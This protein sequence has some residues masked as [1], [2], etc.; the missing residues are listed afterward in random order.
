MCE[1][2][3]LVL[4]LNLKLGMTLLPLG[5]RCTHPIGSHLRRFHTHKQGG[6]LRQPP[7]KRVATRCLDRLSASRWTPVVHRRAGVHR[8]AGVDRSAKGRWRGRSVR[9]RRVLTSLHGKGGIA[10]LT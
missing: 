1:L 10:K 4:Y 2:L 7:T 8:S 9:D 5:G 6:P 3:S